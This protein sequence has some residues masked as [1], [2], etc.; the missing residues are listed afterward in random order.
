MVKVYARCTVPDTESSDRYLS[1]TARDGNV[2]VCTERSN[3][4]QSPPI[5][6]NAKD[7]KKAAVW[8]NDAIER[9]E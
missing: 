4:D 9:G 5:V 3:G 6:V 1:F 7:L 2:A 8:I